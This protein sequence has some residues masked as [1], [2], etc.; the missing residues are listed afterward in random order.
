MYY[1]FI[2]CEAALTKVVTSRRAIINNLD[3][4]F[5]G[6]TL[7]IIYTT[8]SEC[9]YLTVKLGKPWYKLYVNVKCIRTY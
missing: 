9:D 2:A 3:V 5:H 1:K 6:F 4:I 7:Q 8:V